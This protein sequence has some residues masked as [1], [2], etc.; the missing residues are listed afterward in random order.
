MIL[1]I[2]PHARVAPAL[3]Y[4]RQLINAIASQDLLA[5]TATDVIIIYKS[6]ITI[7][8][9]DFIV[10]KVVVDDLLIRL[11]FFSHKHRTYTI[12]RWTK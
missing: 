4:L 9:S 1:A 3:N 12:N 10:Q 2:H 6:D 7:S 8:I 11:K 5:K